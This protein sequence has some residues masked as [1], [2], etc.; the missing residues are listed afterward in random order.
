MKKIAASLIT[1]TAL[2]A[3][4]GMGLDGGELV[5]AGA[6][7][8]QIN[9]INGSSSTLTA[10]TVSPCDAFSHGFNRL[11]SGAELAPGQ[12]YAFTVSAGCYDVQAGYGWGTGYAVA[13]FNNFQVPAGGVRSLTVN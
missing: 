3:G 1:A 5:R 8:G 4:C 11:P 7:T 2:L 6:P 13:D 12:S 10:I 9:V